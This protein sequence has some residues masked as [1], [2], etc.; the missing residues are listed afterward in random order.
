MVRPGWAVDS[1]AAPDPFLALL[2]EALGRGRHVTI[3]A[4][5]HSMRPLVPDGS[6]VLLVPLGGVPKV[7]DVVAYG[8]GANLVIH[9]VCRVRDERITT[10]GDGGSG[11]E[12]PSINT[13]AL[14]GR[15]ACAKTP[16]GW[17][18]RLDTPQARVFGRA[19]ALLMHT[20]RARR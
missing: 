7:G 15:A 10:R 12:E 8:R 1:M 19:L 3:R 11:R 20:L 14:L 6:Q 4:R 5:G 17:V 2:G 18:V 16:G 13:S 9:R